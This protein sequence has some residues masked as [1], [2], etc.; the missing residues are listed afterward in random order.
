MEERSEIRLQYLTVVLDL[1]DEQVSGIRGLQRDHLA[2]VGNIREDFSDVIGAL[3]DALSQIRQNSEGDL[4]ADKRAAKVVRQEY[5]LE[6]RPMQDAI[7][8]ERTAFEETLV[9]MFSAEQSEKYMSLKEL[10]EQKKALHHKRH[11]RG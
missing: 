4:E 6:L 10:R 3:E 2:A 8:I 9:Q 11:G 5:K 7:K 1:T